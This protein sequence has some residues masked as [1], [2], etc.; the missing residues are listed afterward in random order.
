MET[1]YKEITSYMEGHHDEMILLLERLVNI[2]GGPDQPEGVD[3]L[4]DIFKTEFDRLGLTTRSI[5]NERAGNIIISDYVTEEVENDAPIVLSGHFDTVFPAGIL[6]EHAFRR[7]GQHAAKGAGIADM[8]G[9]LVIALYTLKALIHVGYR[10]HPIRM[11]LIG[12]EE[13]LHRNSNTREI[14]LEALAGASMMLNFEPSTKREYLGVSRKGG[15]MVVLE[16]NGIG[17]HSGSGASTGR[18]AI[19]E[20]ASKIIELESRTDIQRGKLINCGLIEGGVSTNTIPA[21]AKAN[22]AMRFSNQET[23]EDILRDIDE[24]VSQTYIQDTT[25]HYEVEAFLDAMEM[26]PAVESLANH[27]IKIGSECGYGKLEK[28]K[29]EGASDA[30]LGVVAGVPTLCGMGIIGEGAHTLEE[31]ADLE[32]LISK[33]VLAVAGIYS[34]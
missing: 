28:N 23:K 2:E 31:M 9:G 8:K 18:S 30:A 17:A 20:L 34:F 12:D 7:I 5:E 6:K 3:Q 32:S 24:V 14:M 22:I 15:G 26:T 13:T 21:Y 11:L 29:S 33:A 1:L 27:F 4:I 10:K 19:V 16:V 25:A